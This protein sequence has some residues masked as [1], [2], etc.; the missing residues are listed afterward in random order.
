[1]KSKIIIALESFQQTHDWA[2]GQQVLRVLYEADPRLRPDRIGRDDAEMRKKLPCEN[3]AD[4][5]PLWAAEVDHCDDIPRH[6]VSNLFW[7]KQKP[8]KAYG[9]FG[10]TWINQKETV[11]P[12]RIKLECAPAADIDF[13]SILE[14]WCVLYKPSQAYLHYFGPLS[15]KGTQQDSGQ[16]ISDNLKL[17]VPGWDNFSNGSFGAVFKPQTYDLGQANCFP[18]SAVT[19]AQ[20]AELEANDIDVAPLGEG[21]LIKLSP[22]LEDVKNNYSDFA[23]KRAIAKQIIGLDRF[24]IKGHS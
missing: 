14:K 21:V 12:S 11:L 23:E 6:P 13:Q 8:L 17:G 3:V 7:K 4:I 16:L 24:V 2:F 1:M 22:S 10:F 5:E 15:N 19:D 20:V 18:K 9:Y